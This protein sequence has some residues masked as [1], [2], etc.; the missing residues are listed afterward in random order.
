VFKRRAKADNFKKHAQG[1]FAYTCD[2]SKRM[3][4]QAFDVE[5][6]GA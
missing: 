6:S 5:R 3:R 2:L 1:G 4:K